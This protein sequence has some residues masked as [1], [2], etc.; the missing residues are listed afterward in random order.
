MESEEFVDRD[1]RYLGK[2]KT[3]NVKGYDTPKISFDLPLDELYACWNWITFLRTIATEIGIT[4][5]R[6]NLAYTRMSLKRKFVFMKNA[7]SNKSLR[8]VMDREAETRLFDLYLER[9]QEM[10][11]DSVKEAIDYFETLFGYESAYSIVRLSLL[12]PKQRYLFGQISMENRLMALECKRFLRTLNKVRAYIPED[13]HFKSYLGY[14]PGK[15]KN[16]PP[17]NKK[18]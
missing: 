9:L 6:R 1:E 18:N 13:V 15:K 7:R 2:I 14:W 5:K 10:M 3:V 17:N 16:P 12:T 11:C 8:F 4:T